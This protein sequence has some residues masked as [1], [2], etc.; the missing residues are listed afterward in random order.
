MATKSKKTPPKGASKT[1]AP[2][3]GSA[4]Q[5]AI[6]LRQVEALMAAHARGELDLGGAPDVCVGWLRR[7]QYTCAMSRDEWPGSQ[8]LSPERRAA[9]GKAD[10]LALEMLIHGAALV[11]P[12][13]GPLR[14]AKH[15]RELQAHALDRRQVEKRAWLEIVFVVEQIARH[16]RYLKCDPRPDDADYLIAH[17]ARFGERISRM[18][19]TDA[20]NGWMKYGK[21]AAM[22]KLVRL[23]GLVP[24]GNPNGDIMRKQHNAWRVAKRKL[25]AEALG[26]PEADVDDL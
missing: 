21:W 26:L 18:Q 8:G 15:I 3:N 16:L 5:R 12:D 9:V 1:V 7:C 2:Q 13:L 24:P 6:Q 11:D 22:Y 4:K 23:C 10:R 17:C 14:E 25:D 19:A 20:I